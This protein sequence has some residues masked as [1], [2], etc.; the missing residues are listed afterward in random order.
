PIKLVDTPSADFDVLLSLLYPRDLRRPEVTTVEGWMS[1]L[2]VATKFEFNGFREL[3]I[4]KLEPIVSPVD[5][6]TLSHELDIPRW[7]QPGHVKL[8]MRTEP[9][10]MA[11][12]S[13]LRMQDV[14]LVF[15]VH[16]K[17]HA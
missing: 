2:R 4:E 14:V 16:G 5:M 3:A 6:I 10:G 11:E 17:V 8:C 1:V 15:T 9:L 12:A 13:R 7:L